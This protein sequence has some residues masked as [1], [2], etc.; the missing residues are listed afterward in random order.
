MS[1]KLQFLFWIFAF[2]AST[3]GCS[4]LSGPVRSTE[5]K[6][7][8]SS[9]SMPISTSTSIPDPTFTLLPNPTVTSMPVQIRVSDLSAITMENAKNLAQIIELS[10][11]M[12]IEMLAFSPDGKY[13]FVGCADDN[14]QAFINIWDLATGFLVRT[15]NMDGRFLDDFSISPDGKTLAIATSGS[16]PMLWNISTGEQLKIPDG[17]DDGVPVVSVAFRP[18]G[19]SLAYGYAMLGFLQV[20]DLEKNMFL[21]EVRAD[22][23]DV[24][25]ISYTFDGQ[26]II[27]GGWEGAVRI[28]DAKTGDLIKSIEVQNE[29]NAEDA[30]TSIDGYTIIDIANNT[31]DQ[32]ALAGCGG[33]CIIQIRDLNSGDFIYQFDINGT[34]W[35][36]SRPEVVFNSIGTILGTAFCTEIDASYNCAK[37][38]VILV[39]MDSF[40]T[41]KN[42]EGF[43]N[44]LAFS[45][46]GK[47]LAIGNTDGL[48]H[49][50]GIMNK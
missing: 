17:P 9:A 16:K 3:T 37:A 19:R 24:N 5:M 7:E 40:T 38:T 50:F 33:E 48:V 32:I 46:D 35:V 30:E 21:Y 11:S 45:P 12:P 27:S 1:Q 23:H 2:F 39:E 29:S 42:I 31:Q 22:T 13:I 44:R 18:T 43:G 47:L 36:S 41:I 6:S 4:N 28:W 10:Q 20:S 15:L 26:K 14:N 34:E 25:S 8:P 49:V